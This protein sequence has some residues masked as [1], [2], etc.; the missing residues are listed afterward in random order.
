MPKKF[1]V[2]VGLCENQIGSEF[3]KQLCLEHGI[4]PNGMLNEK[5]Q[6]HSA[7]LWTSSRSL[8]LTLD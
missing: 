7:A 4:V 1:K 5:Q 3:W 6:Q 8:V 2:Q